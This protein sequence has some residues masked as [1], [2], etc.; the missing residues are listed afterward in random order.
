MKNNI[1]AQMAAV[2][3][4]GHGGFEMLEYRQDI[5]VPA[6]EADEVLLRV[7]AAGINNTD[8]NTRIGWYSK[9]VTTDTSAGGSD[10]Y[11]DTVNE[12]GSWSGEALEFPRIQGADICG[13]IVAVGDDVDSSRIGERVLVRSIQTNQSRRRRFRLSYLWFGVRWWFCSV[14]Q[15]IFCRCFKN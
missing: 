2:L 4:T 5:A 13:V 10:G 8:I 14:C 12:D 6:I 11:S 9:T 15:D 7:G 1:P 3:L